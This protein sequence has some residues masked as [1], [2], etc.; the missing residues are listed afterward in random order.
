MLTIETQDLK[1]KILLHVGCGPT[2][3]AHL[4]GFA[5]SD[6]TERRLDIDPGQNPDYLCSM[7]DMDAVPVQKF[8]AIYS[9]HSLEHLAEFEIQKAL[10]N[11]YR[12]L[13]D[14][15]FVY[16]LCPDMESVLEAALKTGLREKIYN[17]PLGP[18]RPLDVIYGLQSEIAKGKTY[19]AHKT[20][21]T[22]DCLMNYMIKAAFSTVY[23]YKEPSVFEL[24]CLAY[25]KPAGEDRI[26]YDL[27]RY[28]RLGGM[29][30]TGKIFGLAK[31]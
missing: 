23:V 26:G 13:T 22:Q 20:G 1:E 17:C 27:E 2:N 6:W 29:S 18:I 9:S 15:G 7:V 11:F 30:G 5:E 3:K 25:K 14:D 28:F 24:G 16:L 12:S 19:M 31:H 21:F 10:K 4:K 8:D